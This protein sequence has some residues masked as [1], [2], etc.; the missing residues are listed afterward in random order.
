MLA[1]QKPPNQ[2]SIQVKIW[3]IRNWSR[4]RVFTPSTTDI[5][6]QIILCLCGCLVHQGTFSSIFGLCPQDATS[7]HP[8]KLRQ[9][10]MS[11]DVVI[12]C[13]GGWIIQLRTT[14][15]SKARAFLAEGT[16]PPACLASSVPVSLLLGESCHN[17]SY[18]GKGVNQEMGILPGPTLQ[19]WAALLPLS[20]PETGARESQNTAGHTVRWVA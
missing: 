16:R 10:K 8:P 5:W 15:L 6:D 11:P 18:R 13:P 12:C 1:K 17:R 14:E 2:R 20:Q 9:P 7:I 3:M 19:L 4:A